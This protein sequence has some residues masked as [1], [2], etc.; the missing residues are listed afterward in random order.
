MMARKTNALVA[1]A[2]MM[3]SAGAVKLG[4]GIGEALARAPDPAE[5]LPGTVPL[6]CPEP[7]AALAEALRLREAQVATQETAVAER[8]AALDTANRLIDDRMAQLQA[9]EAAL[10]E[11]LSIADGAAEKDI[12]RL[13]AVY[14]AMKPKDAAGLF[15]TMDTE[16]AAGFLGRMR[17][18]AA[19]AVLSGMPAPNAYAVSLLLAGRNA[20]VPTE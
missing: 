5:T 9:A 15:T 19:A 2:L 7:P 18:D 10:A 17:P 13:T 3:A 1:I 4:G 11:T 6:I 8:L 20:L 12:E 16:F 14:E